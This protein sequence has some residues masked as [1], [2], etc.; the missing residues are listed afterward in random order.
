[1]SWFDSKIDEVSPEIVGAVSEFGKA[2]FSLQQLDPGQTIHIWTGG[3]MHLHQV[4]ESVLQHSGKAEAYLCSWSISVPAMKSLLR[5]HS[6][7]LISAIQ[8]VVDFRTRKDH[9]EAFDMAKDLFV[10]LRVHPCHAKVIV[11]MGERMNVSILGSAN[12]TNNPKQ[13]RIVVSAV[14]SVAKWDLQYILEMLEK[15]EEV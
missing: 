12:L 3:K 1:M 14:D 15:G 6:S 13:E 9:P 2:N 10:K 11:L 8:G 7:G 5:L 4:L